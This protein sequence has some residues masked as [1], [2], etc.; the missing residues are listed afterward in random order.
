MVGHTPQVEVV[1]KHHLEFVQGELQRVLVQEVDLQEVRERRLVL[2]TGKTEISNEFPIT[3]TIVRVC[4]YCIEKYHFTVLIIF[5][6]L[7][8]PSTILL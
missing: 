4:Y 1:A 7:A 2:G 5:G 6:V 8:T 3:I